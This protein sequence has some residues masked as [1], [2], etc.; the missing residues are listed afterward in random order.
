MNPNQKFRNRED[1]LLHDAILK[2]NAADTLRGPIRPPGAAG[3]PRL[4]PGR[5]ERGLLQ[6]NAVDTLSR[7]TKLLSRAD[8]RALVEFARTSQATRLLRM[9]K[10][11]SGAFIATPPIFT[12]SAVT[13]LR[14]AARMLNPGVGVLG[15][16]KSGDPRPETRGIWPSRSYQAELQKNNPPGRGRPIVKWWSD[17][18]ALVEFARGDYAVPVMA[19]KGF[20]H[21]DTSSL[22][23]TLAE[24]K[25]LPAAKAKAK[26]HEAVEV[27]GQ[28]LAR[29]A[30]LYSA[31]RWRNPSNAKARDQ[32]AGSLR[33]M[34]RAQ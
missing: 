10:G 25:K 31:A 32:I 29:P 6:R 5:L 20:F 19:R 12:P 22:S 8:A 28:E 14:G 16:H 23:G 21:P 30:K 27:F 18:R 13:E 34:R 9:K 3:L 1:M 33:A 7:K 4:G 24:A 26:A 2:R 17:A 11:V 15:H